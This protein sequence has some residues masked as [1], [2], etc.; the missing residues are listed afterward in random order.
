MKAK[1]S[2]YLRGEE[3]GYNKTMHKGFT[4]RSGRGMTEGDV[5]GKIGCIRVKVYRWDN[6]VPIGV[7]DLKEILGSCGYYMTADNII[8]I[9]SEGQLKGRKFGGVLYYPKKNLYAW[10]KYLEDLGIRLLIRRGVIKEG[11]IA[12]DTVELIGRKKR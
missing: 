9:T 11:G 10:V 7:R 2:S 8:K 4:K 3:R 5:R 6:D 12:K 1:E